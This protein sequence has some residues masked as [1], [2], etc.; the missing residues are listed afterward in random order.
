MEEFD[1]AVGSQHGFLNREQ[2]VEYFGER[3]Y[4]RKV[5]NGELIRELRNF[6][7]VAGVPPSPAQDLFLATFA[8]GGTGSHKGAAGLRGFE[9]YSNVKAEITV[10][11]GVGSRPR[12][13]GLEVTIHRSSYLPASHI[14]VVQGIPITT[15]AR[16]VCDLSRFLSA[17]SLGKVLDELLRRRGID[18]DPG[19]SHPERKLRTWLEDAGL[20]PVVHHPVIVNGTRRELDLAFPAERVAAEYYGIDPHSLPTRVMD[21]STRTTELQLAGWLVVII[22]KA[23]GRRRAVE[24]VKEALELRRQDV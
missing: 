9:R 24:M 6:Y 20:H 23:T 3:G 16:T 18:F 8:L 2:A 12:L 7:R 22:T 17:T 10:G 11:P 15:A 5:A 13:K 1:E 14:E 21:D 19:D 4:K